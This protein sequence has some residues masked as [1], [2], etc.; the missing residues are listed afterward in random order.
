MISVHSRI[1]YLV[2]FFYI[3]L[4]PV[5][6][7]LCYTLFLS[8]FVIH[9]FFH[10]AS[11]CFLQFL[12]PP[13]SFLFLHVSRFL[14]PVRFTFPTPCSFHVSYTPFVSRFLQPVSFTFPTPFVSFPTPCSFHVSYTPVRFT[15]PTPCFFHVSYTPFV[16]RFLHPRSFH[17]SYTPVSFTF[18]T[19][20]FFPSHLPVVHCF[21]PYQSC[22]LLCPVYF[23]LCYIP[24][25]SLATRCLFHIA[26]ACYFTLKS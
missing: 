25:L 15:F 16:S 2:L 9:C 1:C 19:P 23:T 21:F 14:Q 10:D 7:T 20:R 13:V 26:N 11:A 8:F 12:L 18:P 3:F 6:F 17:V 24:F 22:I 5:S 4:H